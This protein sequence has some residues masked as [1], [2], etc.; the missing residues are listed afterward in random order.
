MPKD[1]KCAICGA[2][3]P[4]EEMGCHLEEPLVEKEIY[5]CSFA[6]TQ[7]YLA[8]QKEKENESKSKRPPEERKE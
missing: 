8:Q 4:K 7:V 3:K 2:K 1:V 6:C 5:L